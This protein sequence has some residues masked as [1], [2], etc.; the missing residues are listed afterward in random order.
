MKQERIYKC[1]HCGKII[2]KKGIAWEC[3]GCRRR[4]GLVEMDL[5]EK[6]VKG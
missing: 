6:K 1:N 5:I 4:S 3:N 2:K